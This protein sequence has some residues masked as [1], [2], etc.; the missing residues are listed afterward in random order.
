VVL[1]CCKISAF[2]FNFLSFEA[3]EQL[4][5][6]CHFV[7]FQTPRRSTSSEKFSSKEESKL[8]KSSK[9][10]HRTQATIKKVVANGTTE[11]QEKNGKQRVSVGK[12]SS[13]FSN[14]GFPGNLVKV[15]PSSRKVTD[16]SVQWASLPSSIAKLGKVY[17]LKRQFFS[18]VVAFYSL[19]P[20]FAYAIFTSDFH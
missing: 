9:E 17:P 10:E 14:T 20:R 19:L 8:T 13:E 16:A 3:I 6:Y 4:C 1:F 5:Y 11:E 2:S 15:S 7:V 18:P 12:K